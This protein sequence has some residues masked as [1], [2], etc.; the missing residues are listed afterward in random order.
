M[1]VLRRVLCL[2]LLCFWSGAWA[3]TTVTGFTPDGQV[4]QV[5]QAVARF[6]QP[7]VAFGDLRAPAPFDIDCPVPGSGRWVDAQTWSYDFDRDLPGATSC[8]FTLKPGV[9]DL[10]GQPLAGKRAFSVVTGGPA[11][12][13]SLPREGAERID[14]QQAFVLALSAPASGDSIVKQAWC[15]ADGVSEKIPVKLLQGEQR[16]QALRNDPWFARQVVAEDKGEEATG[17][18]TEAR[19]RADDKAGRLARLVVLQSTNEPAPNKP[20]VCM[21][22]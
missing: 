11:V 10:A 13:E 1:A 3:Q 22:N 15:R 7:M 12:L 2:V 19:V 8:G 21:G 17:M 5:R 20:G 14:E 4:R 9:H 6:S 16:E 18:Y